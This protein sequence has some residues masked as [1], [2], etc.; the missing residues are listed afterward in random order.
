MEFS[1]DE[2]R[3]ALADVERAHRSAGARWREALLRVFDPDARHSA[4]AKAEVLGLP[5]RRA[6]L[7]LGGA[8][9]AMSAVIAAC[10]TETDDELPVT[11]TLP[12]DA[13]DPRTAPP[14]NRELDLNLLRTGQSIELLAVETYDTALGTDHAADPVLREALTLFRDQHADHA[15]T[16]ADLIISQDGEPFEQPNEYLSA[17]VIGPATEALA[18]EEDVILLAVDVENTLAQTYVF[19]AEVLTTPELRQGIMS[20]GGVEA[21]HLAV[22]AIIDEQPPAPF[23][24]M[25]RRA[26][27]NQSGYVDGR[28]GL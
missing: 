1:H 8:T 14:G 5:D 27:I 10:G 28:A 4:R 3:R 26:A 22:L 16:L 17:N 21:R 12:P 25:P 7:R 15:E 18:A 2:A 20:I 13:P 19:S 23:A 9:V 11:G 24:F 6:F